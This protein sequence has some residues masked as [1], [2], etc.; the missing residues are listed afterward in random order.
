MQGAA[1]IQITMLL[2]IYL[3]IFQRKKICKSVKIWHNYGHK[4]VVPFFAHPVCACDSAKVTQV[5]GVEREAPSVLA[6]VVITL[7]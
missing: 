5:D 3:G 4:F 2:Q 1:R 6:C 7:C